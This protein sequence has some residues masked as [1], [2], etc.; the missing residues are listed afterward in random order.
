MQMIIT[1]ENLI[2]LLNL[3]LELEGA[4]AIQYIHHAARLKGAAYRQT[5][6]AIRQF[7][8]E[9][10]QCALTLAE[11]INYLG[12]FVS[13]K[14]GQVHTADANED[15]LWHDLRDEE[16]AVQRLKVRIELARQLN[17][18]ELC[19]RL[20][21]IL[22]VQQKHIRYLKEQL[23]DEEAPSD[24]ETPGTAVDFAH[25]W[26]NRAA[27]VPIRIKKSELGQPEDLA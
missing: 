23:E 16:D 19:E 17:E 14:V 13:E 27:R 7:A 22:K 5:V 12:G 11:Q 15:M 2:R 6:K 3:D 25:E 20:E 18:A 21:T 1:R 10:I 4:G 26:A 9:K 24:G 8:H